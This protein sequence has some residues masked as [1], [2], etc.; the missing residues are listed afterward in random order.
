MSAKIEIM[1]LIYSVGANCL[2]TT[3]QQ[4]KEISMGTCK[5]TVNLLYVCVVV[6]VCVF[7]R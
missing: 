1:K 5:V 7:R 2:I 3:I 4:S 6:Y